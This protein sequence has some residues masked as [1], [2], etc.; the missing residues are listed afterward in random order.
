LTL[1]HRRFSMKRAVILLIVPGVFVATTF[2]K[3]TTGLDRLALWPVVRA[4]VADFKL[5]GAPFPCLKVDLSSDDQR[6]YVVLRSPLLNELIV[7]AVLTPS[8]N[9]LARER[10]SEV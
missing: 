7:S 2:A 4:C 8:S 5:T 9:S 1:A 10:S 6:G 3:S